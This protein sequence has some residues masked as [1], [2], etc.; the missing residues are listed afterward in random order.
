[1]RNYLPSIKK[2]SDLRPSQLVL[3]K[4]KGHTAYDDTRKPV[5]AET[6]AISIDSTE[7]QKDSNKKLNLLRSCHNTFISN[8]SV[9]R[10]IVSKDTKSLESKTAARVK[11]ISSAVQ[12]YQS[13]Y[14][15][16][17]KESHVYQCDFFKLMYYPPEH[18]LAMFRKSKPAINI[19]TVGQIF[20]NGNISKNSIK[21]VQSSFKD[22]QYG[23]PKTL[24]SLFQ[25][26]P[27]NT[28]SNY[29][30]LR[31]QLKIKLKNCFFSEWCRKNGT[32]GVDETILSQKL[33]SCDKSTW[34][35]LDTQNRTLPGVAKDGYY[36][37]QVFIFPDK[38]TIREFEANVIE[39]VAAVANLEWDKFLKPHKCIKGNYNKTWVQIANDRIKTDT[40][41]KFLKSS[42][43]P[44]LLN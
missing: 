27:C 30:F 6:K 15:I 13:A 16:Y 35:Y 14:R 29:A 39:S 33:N 22:K 41:N 31:R 38:H 18:F 19:R 1:M 26:N 24:N 9:K 12:R 10:G 34:K 5:T 7:Y 28:P 8:F 44:Y 20:L 21:N 43:I 3:S 2:V 40:L 37:Y 17:S 42:E 4:L 36:S 11:G 25:N 32:K 23:F